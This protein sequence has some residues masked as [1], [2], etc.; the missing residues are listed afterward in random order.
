MDMLA[1]LARLRRPG[2]DSES[3]VSDDDRN[4]LL[5]LCSA[6]LEAL[7]SADRA[8]R[9]RTPISTKPPGRPPMNVTEK[10]FAMHDVESKGWVETGSVIRVAVDWIMASELSWHSRNYAT[11]LSQ[12]DT[13]R[14]SFKM[15][16][17][18]GHNYTIMHTEFF[19]EC[20]QPG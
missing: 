3:E 14:R 7:S 16:E 18:Q 2:F 6:W 10:I 15:T 20:T 13:A 17:F 11:G 9:I 19:R 5:F 4:E 1:K 8:T 12:A